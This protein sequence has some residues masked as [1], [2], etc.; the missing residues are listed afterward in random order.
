MK[1]VHVEKSYNTFL[2]LKCRKNML[3]TWLAFHMCEMKIN[4]HQTPRRNFSYYKIHLMSSSTRVFF[5]QGDQ[6]TFCWKIMSTWP[7]FCREMCGVHEFGNNT[8]DN[9]ILMTL[10]LYVFFFS[11]LIMNWLTGRWFLNKIKPTDIL[12][13]IKNKIYMK[14]WKHN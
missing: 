14:L 12:E 6:E 4:R 1:L 9:L 3:F 5:L 11:K 2:D 13:F 8:V 10:C 7:Q